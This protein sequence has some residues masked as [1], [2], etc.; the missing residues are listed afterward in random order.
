MRA[1]VS[2]FAC[3]VQGLGLSVAFLVYDM[4]IVLGAFNS[5]TVNDIP[6][7]ENLVGYWVCYVCVYWCVCVCVCCVCGV[8]V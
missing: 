4:G 2:L 6:S 7:E 3:L 8:C 1:C 5:I